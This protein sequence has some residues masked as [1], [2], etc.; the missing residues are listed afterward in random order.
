MRT[1][2]VNRGNLGDLGFDKPDPF[3]L[4]TVIIP[5]EIFSVRANIDIKNGRVQIVAAVFL[6][7]HGFLDGV[8]AADA[9]AVSFGARMF[10]PGPDA[11]QPGNLFRFFFIRRP[12]QMSAI[13]TRSRENSFELQAGDNV[14]VFGVA[15]RVSWTAGSKARLPWARTTAPTLRVSSRFLIVKVYGLGGTKFFAGFAFALFEIN[16]LVRINHVFQGNCLGVLHIDGF[17]LAQIAV[18]GI[19]H[20]FRAFFSAQAAGNALVHIHVTGMPGHTNLK[21][22]LFPGNFLYLRQGKQLDVNVPA[23]LDQFG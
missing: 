16:T 21:I 8:R 11:L 14:G 22:P 20:F 23:D 1:G 3:I 15:K 6:G 4:C 5:F 18:I 13:G 19:R 10:V 2:F 7:Q 17:A 9:G 12:D